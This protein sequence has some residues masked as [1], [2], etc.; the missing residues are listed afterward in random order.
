MLPFDARDLRGQPLVNE[1]AAFYGTLHAPGTGAITD[2]ADL[3]IARDGRR[4]SFTGTV[5]DSL[6]GPPRSCVVT[7]DLSNPVPTVEPLGGTR[8]A[9]LPRWSPDGRTLAFLCDRATPGDHQLHVRDAGGTVR[10]A[11]TVEGVIEWLAWSPDG[12]AV[13]I[14]VA[15]L[16]ADLAGC[17]GGATTRRAAD[18]LPGWMPTVDTGDAEN[19]WRHAWVYDLASGSLTRVGPERLNVWEACWLGASRIAAVASASHSEAAWYDARVVAIDVATGAVTDL[20][21]PTDQC[22]VPAASPDG[23]RL[24]I[25]D[26]IC[27]D[28]MILCGDLRL[29]DAHTG[30]SA[31]VDTR[32]IDVTHAAW[33]DDRVLVFAGIRGLDTAVG[34]VD[35]GSGRVEVLWS[36]FDRTGAGWYPTIAPLPDG[37]ALMIGESWGV[38]PELA[39]ID[40]RGYTRVV[41]FGTAAATARE[42]NRATAEPFTWTARDGLEIQGVLIRPSGPGPHPLVMDIHGG[43]IW[44]CRNR[45]E[46]RLRGAKVLADRGIASLYPNPRGSSGRGR[47]YVRRVK[48]DMGGE[49]TYDYLAGFDA[50]VARGIVDPARLGVTGISYGGFMSSWLVTQ[51]GRF[52]AAAPISPVT[53]WYSQHRTSQVSYFDR[54][55]LDDRPS[56]GDGLYR[57]RSPAFFADG[58]KTPVLVIAGVE[59]RNT[60]PTQALEF[61]RSVLEGG[62][63]SVLVTY[64]NAGHGVRTFPEVIDATAR[65]VGWMLEH[66]RAAG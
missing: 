4:A 38:P 49:D 40:A 32:G 19:L 22:G 23:R 10:A 42:F 47:E 31:V 52:A 54:I 14:G 55:F 30:A 1:I 63:R 34:E 7:V 56:A 6:D 62:G 25:V 58:V 45:W 61:H 24:A 18:A 43:P 44:A 39:R 33:R 16:G 11:P 66:F 64:P 48:G 13:L 46:G 60:P 59:D 8:G 50:A 51:D 20:F 12:R 15:G 36:G 57:S 2:A 9:R 35:V 41:S 37:G 3:D 29:V 27:S 65:Y 17:Q 26:A 53:D 21:R 28:R 5:F